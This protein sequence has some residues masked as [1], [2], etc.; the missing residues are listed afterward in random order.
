MGGLGPGAL[1]LVRIATGYGVGGGLQPIPI[2]ARFSCPGGYLAST[3]RHVLLHGAGDADG[4]SASRD[5]VVVMIA[6]LMTLR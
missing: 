4:T 2:R 5:T 6:P 1:A 3:W